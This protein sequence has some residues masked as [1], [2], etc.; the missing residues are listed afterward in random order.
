MVDQQKPNLTK[1][2][3]KRPR[4][5]FR[6]QDRRN[7]F[8]LVGQPICRGF[9]IFVDVKQTLLYIGKTQVQ[10]NVWDQRLYKMSLERN[11]YLSK[12]NVKKCALIVHAVMLCMK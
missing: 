8:Q 2:I 3:K 10:K 5:I 7:V 11:D 9:Q 1:K 12:L 6:F 4:F